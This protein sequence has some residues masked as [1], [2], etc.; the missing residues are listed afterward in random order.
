MARIALLA[1]GSNEVIRHVRKTTAC[2]MIRRALWEWEVRGKSARERQSQLSERSLIHG[3]IPD[4]LPPSEV[5]GCKFQAPITAN[6]ANHF[7]CLRFAGEWA[8]AATV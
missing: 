7:A 1:A 8:K 5:E 6:T 3:Y 2:A 4:S